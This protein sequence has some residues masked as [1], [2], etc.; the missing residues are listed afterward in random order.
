MLCIIQAP[1][2]NIWEELT[3]EIFLYIGAVSS[4]PSRYIE[5][6][7]NDISLVVV[8]PL[9][10]FWRYTGSVKVLLGNVADPLILSS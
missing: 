6:N 7:T 9:L 5:A 10:M 8:F 2:F 1:Y 3:P 4:L